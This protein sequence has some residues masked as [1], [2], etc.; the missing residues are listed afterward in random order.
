M[1]G[2]AAVALLTLAAGSAATSDSTSAAARQERFLHLLRT[3]PQRPPR[4]TL[5][6]VERL[7]EEGSFPDHDRAE[8]WLGSAWLALQEREA[9]RRWFAR[10]ASDHPAS[11][12]VERS[13]LG[14]GDAAAQER[15]YGVA[16]DWYAKARAARDAAVREMGRISE[17]STLTLRERQRWAWAA[18]GIALVVSGLLAASLGR[19]R[20]LRLWPLP[21]E[22][23]IVF[24]VLAVLALLSVR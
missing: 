23:R 5:A 19:H 17:R 3:Y 21:A 16:L 14:L 7:V 12:W 13:W 8:G 15:R 6:Q 11:V 4:D 2:V 18:G 20:P 24:P 1:G 10:V 9:A 22:A